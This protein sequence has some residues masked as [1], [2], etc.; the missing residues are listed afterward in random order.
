MSYALKLAAAGIAFMLAGIVAVVLVTN[1][2]FRIGLG[3]AIVVLGGI[4]LFFAWRSD[5]KA[6]EERAGLE[7]I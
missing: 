3:S 4:L 7:R 1:L 2:W 5:R 6:K